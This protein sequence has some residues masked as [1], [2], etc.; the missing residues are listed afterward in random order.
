MKSGPGNENV[1]LFPPNEEII[2]SSKGRVRG[3]ERLGALLK[4]YRCEA[5]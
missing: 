2:G 3:K 4:Y 1:L 5:A